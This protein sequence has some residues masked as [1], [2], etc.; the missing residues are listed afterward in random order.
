MSRISRSCRGIDFDSS[1]ESTPI[2]GMDSDLMRPGAGFLVLITLSA[3]CRI[4]E[5]KRKKQEKRPKRD[6]FDRTGKRLN[7]L[8]AVEAV[9]VCT[10]T[11]ITIRIPSLMV[12]KR[13]QDAQLSRAV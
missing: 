13:V 11:A 2:L 8:L 7:F 10:N 1:C 5:K 6:S 4:W 9:V 12:E 3:L